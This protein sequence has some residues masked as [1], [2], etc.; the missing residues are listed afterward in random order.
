MLLLCCGAVIVVDCHEQL[1]KDLCRRR[2]LCVLLLPL[3]P[4][5]PP[6]LQLL[7]GDDATAERSLAEVEQE[8]TQMDKQH[9]QIYN[10]A[11]RW[12]R[13][14]LVAG[15]AVLATQVCVC[16]WPTAAFDCQTC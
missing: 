15:C 2:L 13:R 1:L 12:A 6:P 4:P 3:L 5:P 10:H 16:C 9:K 14:W 7:P 8:L 11:Q